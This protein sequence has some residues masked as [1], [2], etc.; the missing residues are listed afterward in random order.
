[1]RQIGASAG[2]SHS[3]HLNDQLRERFGDDVQHFDLAASR[4]I[5]A[6]VLGDLF[7]DV[8]EVSD[9]ARVP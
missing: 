1:M 9:T 5:R 6:D 4:R 7:A 2:G 3:T 8:L